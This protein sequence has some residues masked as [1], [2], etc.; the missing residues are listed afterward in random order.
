MLLDVFLSF[1]AGVLGANAFPHFV[2]GITKE[3]YPCIFGNSAVPNFV[4]G[5]AGFVAT[6]VLIYFADVPEH[7]LVSFAAGAAGALLIGL[8][9]AKIGAFGKSLTNDVLNQTEEGRCQPG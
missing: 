4:A 1:M 3:S 8:F 7:A 9:H 6:A 5:W 2:K